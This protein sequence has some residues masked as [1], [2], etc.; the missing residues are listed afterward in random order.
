MYEFAPSATPSPS[1]HARA[2][3]RARTHAPTAGD[4][5][6]IGAAGTPESPVARPRTTSSPRSANPMP[7][8]RRNRA[9]TEDEVA[10]RPLLGRKLKKEMGAKVRSSLSGFGILRSERPRVGPCIIASD[11]RLQR[12]LPPAAYPSKRSLIFFDWDD[13]LCPTS[14]I[15]HMVK[16][17]MADCAA[18]AVGGADEDDAVDELR[19]HIPAW[20][21]QPLTDF[22]IEEPIGALQRAVINVIECA[23]ELGVVVIVTNSVK[24]WVESS[25][26]QWMPTLMPYLFGHGKRPPLR[27]IYGQEAFSSHM[28]SLGSPKAAQ[29]LAHVDKELGNTMLWKQAAMSEALEDIDVVYRMPPA[30]PRALTQARILDNLVS[31]GDDRPEITAPIHALTAHQHGLACADGRKR[32]LSAPPARVSV[33]LP[34]VKLLKLKEAPS[35]QDLTEELEMIRKVLPHLIA[36]RQNMELE[37]D[38]LREMA[39]TLI[40]PREVE[41]R[42]LVMTQSC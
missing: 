15:R 38:D 32:P 26:R 9:A 16:M 30:R 2:R 22:P 19:T 31:I 27:I 10:T 34:R 13:T 7:P 40:T 1:T 23:Q 5:P 28:A 36:A 18:W 4:E 12:P 6:G 20:F 41:Q 17:Y 14:W 8:G 24:D 37:L 11:V 25:A 21:K 39:Q 42:R 33:R 3:A 29:Q 35:I